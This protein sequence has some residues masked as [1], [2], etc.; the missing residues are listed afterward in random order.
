MLQL[1]QLVQSVARTPS[2]VLL[3]GESGV[4]KEVLA[5]HIHANSKRA[6]APFVGVNCAALSQSLLESELF[7]HE[8]GA[9]TGATARHQGV[10]ERAQ[11]GTILLDE[12][13]EISPDTQGRLLR[14]LQERVMTRV[15]G[16][17]EIK[18]DIRI[19]ATTNRNLREWVDQ[20]HFRL[21]LYYRLNV[22]PLHIPPLRQR[23][24]DIAPLVLYH[25]VRLAK[26]LGSSVRGI[27]QAALDRLERYD[28]PGNVRELVNILERAII[29]AHD[30]RW[31]DTE[32]LL[33]D[34]SLTS[35]PT[36]TLLSARNQG[37]RRLF[38][39]PSSDQAAQSTPRASLLA[40][41]ADESLSDNAK[42]IQLSF[43]PGSE[44]LTD[45]RRKVILGTLE[46]FHGN[47]TRTA[48]ALGVSL[49]TIRNKLKEYRERGA[50]I[51]L[52]DREDDDEED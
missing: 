46:R 14:V 23:R 22:F 12:I 33:I 18:L 50:H 37:P 43:V 28:Y 4:G 48:K 32:H 39:E 3:V 45:V 29:L 27:S 6:H 41:D 31:I 47:R 25:S 2:T 52:P 49:R 17:D 40:D 7:G 21:D 44:P 1:L 11:G 5:R 36:L 34:P 30:A 16:V 15:G 19:I 51:D 8:K 42:H 20:G 26:Q 13:S 24:A 35:P 10:F 9:F 38:P